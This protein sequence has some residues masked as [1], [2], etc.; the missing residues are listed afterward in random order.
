MPLLTLL[1][2][3]WKKTIRA[4][5]FHNNLAVNILL[6]LTAL[7][8]IVIFFALGLFL[9]T[10]LSGAIPGKTPTQLF[11][12]V[13]LYILL[14]GLMIRYFMQQLATI[15]IQ[16]Y[17]ILPIKRKTIIDFLLF[18]PLLNP[19]NFILFFI[20]IPFAI[21]SVAVDYNITTAIC[22]VVNF[23]LIV[24]FN[25]LTA[26]FIKRKFGSNFWGFFG[27]IIFFALIIVLDFFHIF[28]LFKISELIFNFVIFNPFGLIIPI[29]A[30]MAAYHLNHWFFSTYYYA[31]KFDL[32]V[33]T[34]KSYGDSNL[35]F[36]NR[37]GSIGDIMGLIMKLVWRHKRTKNALYMTA[38]FLFYGLLF[39]T[40][41][42]YHQ[43]YSWL[44]F[45]AMFITGAVMLI[46]CQWI[47]AMNSTHF[48]S[49]M[50]KNISI[51]SYI[52]AN[53]Y[54]ILAGNILCFVLTLP[55]F[56]YGK[57][58][59]WVH[60]AAIL[61]NCGVNAFLLVF[62][63][64]YSSKRIDLSVRSVANYQGVTIKN[65]I[66]VLPVLFF[67]MLFV[68]LF[69]LFSMANIALISLSVLGILGLVFQKQLITM[70]ENQFN[71]RKY[72]MCEGFRQAE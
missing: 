49:L 13:T 52:T 27:V 12:G 47:I 2:Q 16:L 40:N 14:G 64:T 46:F 9:P 60:L 68:G 34:N 62:F 22:F 21:R 66:V 4:R 6:G 15:N 69:S 55:Y 48:D 53:I 70:C 59:A 42:Y 44:F 38:I 50:T 65:F 28:S 17:Q 39:Y 71:R 58:I 43:Q 45:C 30:V 37:F 3:N 8:F 18:S 56:L 54:L 7:Y 20:I 32:K 25:S 10:W 1:K 67:P 36:L 61:Y 5:G 26:S 29:G 72:A 51:R 33:S 57:E 31:E 35:S 63:G 24:C 23:F 11:N 41:E 19:V